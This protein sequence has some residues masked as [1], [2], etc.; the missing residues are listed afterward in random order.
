MN[1]LITLL[2]T[3]GLILGSVPG[4]SLI[5]GMSAYADED[6]HLSDAQKLNAYNSIVKIK[7][8]KNDD[9]IITRAEAVEII[10]NTFSDMM[11]GWDSGILFS[12]YKDITNGFL[13]FK[14]CF[15]NRHSNYLP[16]KKYENDE[17]KF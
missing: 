10:Y 5:L 3:L 15:V 13:N 9:D 16:S 14:I 17:K 4:I 6:V 8:K 12:D 11:S 1:K 7:P 2:T